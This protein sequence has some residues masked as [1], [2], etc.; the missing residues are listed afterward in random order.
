MFAS[1][2]TIDISL[3]I[4]DGWTILIAGITLLVAIMTY[5]VG[6]QSKQVAVESKQVAVES[7][8]MAKLVRDEAEKRRKKSLYA[9]FKIIR[10]CIEVIEE[11]TNALE[12]FR[13]ELEQICQKERD[14]DNP[15]DK[16]NKRTK[17]GIHIQESFKKWRKTKEAVFKEITDNV[18]QLSMIASRSDGYEI[19]VVLSEIVRDI[20]DFIITTDTEAQNW[21]PHENLHRQLQ[22]ATQ[23]RDKEFLKIHDKLIINIKSFKDKI[24]KIYTEETGHIV[25]FAQSVPIEMNVGVATIT[26]GT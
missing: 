24:G 4:S 23:N 19:H 11:K 2:Q 6:Q 16:T 3:T 21:Q 26:N 10:A 18:S 5:A 8:E 14:L 1:T 7:H 9:E 20:N 22:M 12:V 17:N 13:G 25:I 15:T